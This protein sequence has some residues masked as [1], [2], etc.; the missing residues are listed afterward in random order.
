MSTGQPSNFFVAR[1]PHAA[2]FG[3]VA[4]VVVFIFATGNAIADL[5]ERYAAVAASSSLLNQLEGRTIS[6]RA[7]A[8]AAGEQVPSGSPFLEGQTVTIAG[9]VLLQ[10]VIGAVTRVGGQVLS[11]QVD[12]QGAHAKED[13]VGVI[14]N[15]EVDQPALQRLLYDIEAGMPFLF[16]DQLIVQAPEGGAQDGGR[17]RVLLGVSG[18]WRGGR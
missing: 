15:C 14:A 18:Q 11:S 3:Y 13:Y 1:H 4:L 5:Y 8:D 2:V 10:R 7:G 6:S 16:I 9:A 12:L 17:M